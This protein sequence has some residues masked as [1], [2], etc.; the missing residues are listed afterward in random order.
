MN[1]VEGPRLPANPHSAASKSDASPK[2]PTVEKAKV[3]SEKIP[4]PRAKEAED[5]HQRVHRPRSSSVSRVQPGS[6]SGIEA[7]K[8]EVAKR[9]GVLWDC[10]SR[11]PNKEGGY[12]YKF[13]L[14]DEYDNVTSKNPERLLKAIDKISEIAPAVEAPAPGVRRYLG[15]ITEEEYLIMTI[16]ENLGGFEKIT[17]KLIEEARP[18]FSAQAKEECRAMKQIRAL[19]YDAEFKPTGVYFSCPDREALTARWEDLRSTHPELPKFDI[20]SSEG[21]ADDM[22]FVEALFSHDALLSDGKE[23]FHDQYAHLVP[24]LLTILQSKNSEHEYQ[25]EKIRFLSAVGKVLRRIL[26]VEQSLSRAESDPRIASVMSKLNEIKAL[27]GLYVDTTSSSKSIEGIRNRNIRGYIIERI[28]KN[29]DWN[30]Y[31]V[32]RFGADYAKQKDIINEALWD[33][34]E[35]ERQ[36]DIDRKRQ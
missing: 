26:I 14:K 20:I 1:N 28:L 32:N 10:I 8:I 29:P 36:Y 13:R 18:V 23:F 15:G 4:Q 17:P 25:T 24:T 30:D 22:A 3:Q 19:G 11:K 33:L 16:E 12:I 9:S 21:I 34:Q 35:I 31:M 7:D 27:L 5:L 2:N 6:T